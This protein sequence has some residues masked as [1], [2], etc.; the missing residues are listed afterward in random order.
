[1]ITGRSDGT[2]VPSPPKSGE[3]VA[4]GRMRGL[5][6]SGLL[7]KSMVFN[8]PHPDPLPPWKICQNGSSHAGR[9]GTKSENRSMRKP[10]EAV[11]F[12][13][14]VI[15]SF[16]IFLTCGT[17]VAQ[18]KPPVRM[19]MELMSIRNRSSG[20][21]PVHIKLEY[22]RPQILEGDLVLR[23]YDAVDVVSRD[24]L[25]A[26][27][28]FEGIVLAGTD[29]EFNIVLPP[30]KTAVTQNWA[31]EAEFVTESGSIQLSSRAEKPVPVEPFDLLTT[32]PME[33]GVLLC[34][35]FK[36]SRRQSGSANR[37]FLEKS[38]SLDNYNPIYAKLEAHPEA[39]DATK[40]SG[41]QQLEKIGRTVI[42]FA[43]QW[44]SKDLPHDPLSYCAFDVV[45]L[46]DESLASLEREQ[47]D[48][49]SAW[50]RAGGSV[51]IVPDVPMKPL[52]LE[53]LRKLFAQGTGNSAD[54]SLDSDGRLLVISDETDPI[55]MSH[56]GLGRAVL[57]P[58]LEDFSARLTKEDLGSIVAFLWKVRREQP[59]WKGEN[60][61]PRNLLSQLKARGVNAEQDERGIFSRDEQFRYMTS[62]QVDG[63]FYLDSQS[64]KAQ[65]NIDD[66]IG[67]QAEPL[68]AV[69]E[70]ALLPSDV[71]MVPTWMIGLIL[72]GYVMAIGPGD[73]FLLGW[74][75]MR[76]YTWVLFPVIT[77]VFTMLTVMVAN[78][79]M[80]SEDT[81]GRLVITDLA[82]NG[83]P[84]RQTTLE[85]LYYSSQANVANAHKGELVVLSEDNFSGLDI[86][87][88]Y[89]QPQ[90]HAQDAPLS[91]SGHFPQSYSVSHRVQQWSPVSLRTLSLEPQESKVPPIDWNDVTLLTTPE[92]RNL[93]TVALRQ[94]AVTSQTE[95]HAAIF[96]GQEV[97]TLVGTLNASITQPQAYRVNPYSYNDNGWS[98][99]QQML[100]LIPTVKKSDENFF[101][102]VCQIAPHGAG[103]L[104]DLAI[105][106]SS[107]LDQ[108]A[109]VIVEHKE[110]DF[111]VFRKLYLIES[112]VPAAEQEL[113]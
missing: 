87:P 51:C 46:S 63:K 94:Q 92:G 73:Y 109:L 99:T 5:C 31:V 57:L 54:L 108:W 6:G 68:L 60:W 104:E 40:A 52:Q 80:G 49:L 81:G 36:D 18:D 58:A 28:R 35:C 13:R 3:K 82:D 39:A 89:G 100:N 79:F 32:S 91:Y 53:F 70:Q 101:S 78:A 12:V 76:K 97:I 113:P 107:D 1:M 71:E 42:Y 65:Y 110:D 64:L 45:L 55:L 37:T 7:R 10:N 47:L 56:Y 26:T 111:H 84:V 22:N 62:E 102:I 38:L 106:D 90:Q 2:H 27:L 43:G 61:I 20:P 44:A 67:P 77:A 4:E 75:K 95:C 59:V 74:L 72:M 103:S 50:V 112:A 21:L 8:P 17:A 85:T 14:A 69:A 30:L 96:H 25:L 15:C 23:V 34:S 93:A 19:K 105:L 83:V 86:Y 66:R 29:Y 24:D 88:P 11:P 33:R 9:E 16:L 48:G 98:A 41:V